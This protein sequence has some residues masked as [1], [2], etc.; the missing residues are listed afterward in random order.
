MKKYPILKGLCL[1]CGGR[2]NCGIGAAP[3]RRGTMAIC[4]KYVPVDNK[5][6]GKEL[7]QSMR[8]NCHN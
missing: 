1:T 7:K 8:Y 6:H 4:T 2:G 3:H 5:L